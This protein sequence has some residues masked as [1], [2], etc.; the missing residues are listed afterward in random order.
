MAEQ[1]SV[2]LM[3]WLFGNHPQQLHYVYGWLVHQKIYWI[4][5]AISM[6]AALLGKQYC[7]WFTFLGFVSGMLAGEWFGANPN[8]SAIGQGHYG[9]LIWGGIFLLSV[10]IGILLEKKAK[11]RALPALTLGCW[12]IIFLTGC[13]VVVM[14][15]KIA[16]TV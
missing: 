6:A 13:F 7:S 9:W 4:A 10:G 11:K 14:L 3:E 12:G 15:V 1:E 8:A 5:M 2:S 16:M